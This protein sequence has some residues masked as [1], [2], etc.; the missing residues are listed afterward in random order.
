VLDPRTLGVKYRLAVKDIYK[1]SLSPYPDD[2]A[3]I[4]VQQQQV[5]FSQLSIFI[6]QTH[7][8]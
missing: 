5:A 6:S 3:V 4:H 2:I 8:I 7:P 1:I